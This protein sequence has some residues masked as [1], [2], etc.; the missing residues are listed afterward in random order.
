MFRI[1]ICLAVGLLFAPP[2]WAD[3]AEWSEVTPR[4]EGCWSGTGFD[5]EVSEC[6][7][8][9]DD[10]RADGMLVM[11]SDGKP[12]FSQI[13]TIDMFDGKPQM[14]LKHVTGDMTGWEEKGDFTDFTFVSADKDTLSFKGLVLHFDGDMS[15]RTYIDMK[16]RD[17]QVRRMPFLYSRVSRIADGAVAED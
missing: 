6:W 12:V 1:P 9:H 7:L 13:L 8:T 17:G 3:G 16:Q 5:N 4:L 11:R 15:R 10:G 2:A 14:R